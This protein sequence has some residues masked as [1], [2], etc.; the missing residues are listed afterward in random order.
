MQELI[1]WG[2][3]GDFYP[4]S[5]Q[6]KKLER[7]PTKKDS[8][9]WEAR[10]STKKGQLSLLNQVPLVAINGLVGGQ[11]SLYL[12]YWKNLT[13]DPYILA[14]IESGITVDLIDDPP[15]RLLAV[16]TFSVAQQTAIN[17]ELKSLLRRRVI[18]PTQLC[19]SSYVSPIFTTEKR[20]GTHRL[21]LKLKNV[22]AHERYM[23]YKM[24]S[25]QNVFSLMQLGVWMASIDLKDA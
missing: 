21:I 25:L 24:E 16:T 17:V 6:L 11:L 8:S 23:H 4:T 15:H 2:V 18:V 1:K 5:K 19:P 14:I 13:N 3:S 20:D 7:L 10:S 22:N 9:Q 12:T